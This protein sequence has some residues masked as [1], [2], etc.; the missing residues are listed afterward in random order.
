MTREGLP[1]S[2]DQTIKTLVK[3]AVE[4]QPPAEVDQAWSLVV[5]RLKYRRGPTGTTRLIYLSSAVI[6]LLVGT[7][8]LSTPVRAIGQHLI[9]QV[10]RWMGGTLR[11]L[12]INISPATIEPQP[13]PEIGF[14]G[15]PS[16]S[17]FST[18][19]SLLNQINHP[20]AFVEWLPTD[21]SFQKAE[22][23]QGASGSTI[24]LRSIFRNG[25]GGML[26]LIQRPIEQGIG[27]G[28]MYDTD[29]ATLREVDISGT[30]GT[31]LIVKPTYSSIR[32]LS[33]GFALELVGHLGPEESLAVARSVQ[34]RAGPSRS[35]SNTP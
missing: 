26:L 19:E 29:D 21:W 30:T 1:G 27:Q 28:R 18:V 3:Q 12:V 6:T 32:W 7:L 17:T 34:F 8:V 31:L 23:L 15:T 25:S 13:P 9:E 24:E 20:V 16:R 11:N 4:E 10:N 33:H 5:N 22:I 2:L 35:Q 14:P